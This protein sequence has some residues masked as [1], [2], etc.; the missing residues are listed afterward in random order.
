MPISATRPTSLRP[1]SS[2]IR[3]S[4]RSLGSASSSSASAGPRAG[5]A[6]RRRVPAIGRIV[7]LPSRTRTRISGLEPIDREAVEV[8]EVEEGRGVHAA[9]RA[10]ERE[11]RQRELGL[12]A[13]GQHHLED[14][15]R[16]DVVLRLQH[17]RLVF[18]RRWCWSAALPMGEASV[19]LQRQM[20]QRPVERVDD[21]A[22]PLLRAR[23][24]GLAPSRPARHRRGR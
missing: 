7:T 17:H 14:V 12:E 13:L 1:R 22:D 10:V 24:G 5:V 21:L 4:A 16:R 9:Q 19:G 20:V 23:I 3:C 18:V 8:E 11:G 15:A 2:S 6:P